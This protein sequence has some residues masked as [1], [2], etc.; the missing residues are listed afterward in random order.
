MLLLIQAVKVAKMENPASQAVLLLP[1]SGQQV[2]CW[3]KQ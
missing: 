1:A 3:E 2:W